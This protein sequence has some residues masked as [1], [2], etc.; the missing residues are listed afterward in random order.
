[1]SAEAE[2]VAQLR[3]AIL[4]GTYAPNQRLIEADLCEQFGA[5]RFVIRTAIKTLAGAG[6]VEVQRH[7]GARVRAVSIQEAI[8]ITE[9]RRE[10]EGLGAARAAQRCG[11]EDAAALRAIIAAMR[12]SVKAGELLVYSD[13]NAQLHAEVR[14]IAAHET[15]ARIIEQMRG[16]MVRHQFSLSLVPG[17]PTVSLPQHEAIAKAIIAGDAPA[18]RAAMCAHLDSVVEALRSLSADSARRT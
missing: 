9:V 10:L 11:R 5:T 16:Q 6:L 2:V 12:T 15:S 4:A 3:A 1:M 17:R 7:R 8:E 14:R 13:L 18:A